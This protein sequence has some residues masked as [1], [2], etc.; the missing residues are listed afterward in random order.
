[1]RNEYRDIP[2]VS[3]WNGGYSCQFVNAE[4][5]T[6]YYCRY[7]HQ[8]YHFKFICPEAFAGAQDQGKY[9]DRQLDFQIF[10]CVGEI[11]GWN[12]PYYMCSKYQQKE[13][14]RLALPDHLQP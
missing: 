2:Q 10:E 13:N 11:M 4:K 7:K 12:E 9:E 5:R 8:Q 1:M 14:Y 6:D 3:H